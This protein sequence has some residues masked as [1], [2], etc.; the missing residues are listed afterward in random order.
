MVVAVVAVVAQIGQPD[1]VLE[2]PD[3]GEVAAEYLTDGTPV[4][5]VHDD[6]GTVHVVEAVS[7][8]HP[9]GARNA[10]IYC[11]SSG[12]FEEL[13]HGEKFAR[14][15]VWLTGPAPADLPTYEVLATKDDSVQVGDRVVPDGRSQPASHDPDTAE[16]SA[17]GPSCDEST[18]LGSD[19]RDVADDILDRVVFH[20]PG[21]RADDTVT[22]V[23]RE[24]ILGPDDD[25]TQ[26][27][28]RATEGGDDG[29]LS[30]AE[31]AALADAVFLTAV[32]E[33]LADT[34][35]AGL[36]D[37]APG[38]FLVTAEVLC[39]RLDDGAEPDDLLVEYLDALEVAR[40]QMTDSDALLAGALLGASVQVYCPEHADRLP[41]D[42]G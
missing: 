21:P 6:D 15:G 32:D 9:D 40:N 20:V 14:D 22:Y 39:E 5:V 42:E 33:I 25:E 30:S 24:D 2:L 18:Y 10:L 13:Q 36:V 27:G 8:H 12:W 38:E 11:R 31:Q 7:T 16:H 19:G 23:R 34:E 37:A 35:Y 4:F 29:E 41:P 3:R 1:R 26:A 17:R 28:D